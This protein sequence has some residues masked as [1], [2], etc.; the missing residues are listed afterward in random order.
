MLVSVKIINGKPT[1]L[2]LASGIISGLV[3]ITPATDFVDIGSGII[4]GIPAGIIPPLFIAYVKPLLGYD[5]AL[6]VFA[7]HGISSVIGSILT[8]LSADPV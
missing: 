4:I 3:A 1:I 6:N 8:G 2:G 7:V 5:D